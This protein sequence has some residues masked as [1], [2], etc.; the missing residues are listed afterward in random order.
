VVHVLAL[1]DSSL[2]GSDLVQPT[3]PLC[4]GC[5]FALSILLSGGLSVVLFVPGVEVMISV[6][7]R[8]GAVV[9]SPGCGGV[10]GGSEAVKG[11]LRWSA[12]SPELCSVRVRRQCF[13]L[14]GCCSFF[15]RTNRVVTVMCSIQNTVV[16]SCC[17][18]CSC[19]NIVYRW[20][21]VL[22]GFDYW[23]FSQIC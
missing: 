19:S 9:V 3:L 21:L 8:S 23:F 15:S 5:R 10:A 16:C 13:V 4:G 1:L 7:R 12:G 14:C 22:H 20:P 17:R 18:R 2:F 11:V 6:R